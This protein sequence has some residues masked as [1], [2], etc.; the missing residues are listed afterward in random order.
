MYR[1]RRKTCRK[2]FIAKKKNYKLI[3][4]IRCDRSKEFHYFN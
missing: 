3:N 2:S 4:D 1:N